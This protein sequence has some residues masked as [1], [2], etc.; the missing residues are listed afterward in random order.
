MTLTHKQYAMICQCTWCDS[1]LARE[2]MSPRR[3]N[4]K[5]FIEER[6]CYDINVFER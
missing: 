6:A 3:H 2:E 4:D 1:A 5:G